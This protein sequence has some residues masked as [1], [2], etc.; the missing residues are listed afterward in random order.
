MRSSFRR[1]VLHGSTTQRPDFLQ[2]A[3]RYPM[4]RPSIASKGLE[5]GISFDDARSDF[6]TLSLLL[7]LRSGRV[8]EVTASILDRV[9][10]L[11]PECENWS[12]WS[13]CALDLKTLSRACRDRS[14]FIMVGFDVDE[15]AAIG[16]DD[17]VT[18]CRFLSPVNNVLDPNSGTI[19]PCEFGTSRCYFL[20]VEWTFLLTRH[21]P[22]GPCDTSTL[23]SRS[24][25]AT[26]IMESRVLHLR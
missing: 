16:L 21:C 24:R 2:I 12:F 9:A 15:C 18:K 10:G 26:F 25:S 4:P 8:L 14:G 22:H 20:A 5:R 13:A 3:F 11:S 17:V 7:V 23:T 6:A 19:L 1:R